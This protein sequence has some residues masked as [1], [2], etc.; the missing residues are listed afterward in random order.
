MVITMSK[1]ILI[2]YRAGSAY[3][4]MI[5][6]TWENL[7]HAIRSLESI[8]REVLRVSYIGR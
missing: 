7:D 3:K 5:F 1:N 6:V 4:H 8:N 2:V